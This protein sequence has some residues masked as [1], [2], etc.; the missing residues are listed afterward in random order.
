MAKKRI[1][2]RT[3]RRKAPPKRKAGVA[4]KIKPDPKFLKRLTALGVSPI[5]ID[6]AALNIFME[7][8]RTHRVGEL[9]FLW[10]ASVQAM[11]AAAF[12][13]DSPEDWIKAARK[14][15]GLG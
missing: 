11:K 12:Q 1:T 15:A 8:Q 10:N 2:K 6:E 14:A 9:A 7:L 13:S 5:V 3:V 4:A